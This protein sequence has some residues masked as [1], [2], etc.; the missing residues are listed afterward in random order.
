[1][2]ADYQLRKIANMRRSG[3]SWSKVCENMDVGPQQL[4]E[5]TAWEA[6]QRTARA[7]VL[8]LIAKPLQWLR[9]SEKV[10]RAIAERGFGM[11]WLRR[12]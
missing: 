11:M 2:L 4:Q 6:K 7:G 10:N 1:M 8:A 5:F 12:K 9:Q 3:A